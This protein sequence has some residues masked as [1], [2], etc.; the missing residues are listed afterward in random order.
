MH[1]NDMTLCFVKDIKNPTPTVAFTRVS[2][3]PVSR[4]A[5][6]GDTMDKRVLLLITSVSVFSGHV[7]AIQPYENWP[8][9]TGPYLGQEPPGLQAEMFAP[10]IISTDQSEINSV[11]T[12]A[13]DEFYFTTWTREA[14]TKILVSRLLGGRW[15]APD[16]AS[17]STHPSDVD[18]AISHDGNLRAVVNDQLAGSPS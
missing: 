8:E 10:G 6:A 1:T 7:S 12:H 15:S 3:N 4:T 14:G 11:F 17:F 5:K 9:I 16:L 2:G 13:G 18:P